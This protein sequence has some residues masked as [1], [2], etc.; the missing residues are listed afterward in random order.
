MSPLLPKATRTANAARTYV[1]LLWGRREFAW[2]VAMGNLKARNASTFLG[3][4]WWVLNPLLLGLVYVFVFG[5]ILK[6]GADAPGTVP[7]VAWLLSGIFPFYFTQTALT[8]GVSS[9]VSN[10]RLLANLSFPRLVMPISSLIEAFVGFLASI[11]AYML[12]V[13]FVSGI[14]PTSRI[15]MLLPVIVIHTI[16]NLGLSAVVARLAVPFR[17]LNNL[18]PYLTRVWL[19]LSP[20]ILRPEFIDNLTGAR[21]R[22]FQTNPLFP[23]LAIYR[24][25]LLGLP[26]DNR[27]WLEAIIWSVGVFVVGLL[28]FVTYE[29]KMTRYL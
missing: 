10:S 20:I 8:G 25:A 28:A 24:G 11:V 6:R 15:W 29:G 19:Y 22:V 1:S 16:F 18:V 21:L 2:Y 7:Y 9:I 14:W 23:I 27:F 5:V 17:D 4:F 3:L 26:V 12:I 13:G